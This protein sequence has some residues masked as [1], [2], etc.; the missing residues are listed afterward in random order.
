MT[1]KR[2]PKLVN[3]IADGELFTVNISFRSVGSGNQVLPD[4]HYSHQFADEYKGE[5]PASY[6]L[7]RDVLMMLNVMTSMTVLNTDVDTD[8]LSLD[9]LAIAAAEVAELEDNEDKTRH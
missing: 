1:D 8:E 9:E 2:E 6:L 4:V 5:F 3:E 7:A